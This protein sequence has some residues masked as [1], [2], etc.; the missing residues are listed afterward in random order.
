[1]KNIYQTKIETKTEKDVE[2]KL[3]DH[4]KK[5]E[6]AVYTEETF[7]CPKKVLK[8]LEDETPDDLSE[9]K[10]IIESI[11]LD[12]SYYQ[13]KEK[14]REHYLRNFQKLLLSNSLTMK[15]NSSNIKTLNFMSQEIYLKDKEALEFKLR[16][17][18]NICD[19]AKE[20]LKVYNFITLKLK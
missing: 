18:S 20:Y 14:H 19:D 16:N 7:L 8:L 1:M 15:N 12:R 11:L 3:S 10:H 4:F 6:Q 2:Y 13:L 17:K 5:L 9:Y